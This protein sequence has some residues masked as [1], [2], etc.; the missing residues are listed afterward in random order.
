MMGGLIN[1][2]NKVY[3]NWYNSYIDAIGIQAVYLLLYK[4][5]QPKSSGKIFLCSKSFERSDASGHNIALTVWS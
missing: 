1:K 3:L 4:E 5:S 2:L